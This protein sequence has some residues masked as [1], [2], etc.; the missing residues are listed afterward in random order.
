[1]M[2]AIGGAM[3]G[4]VSLDFFQAISEDDGQAEAMHQNFESRRESSNHESMT[5]GVGN[6]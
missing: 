2:K 6:G 3:S 4:K 1:M 5:Q